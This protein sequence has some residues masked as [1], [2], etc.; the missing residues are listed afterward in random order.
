VAGFEIDRLLKKLEMD[1]EILADPDPEP[2]AYGEND[3]SDLA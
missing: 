1:K 2:E 3:A